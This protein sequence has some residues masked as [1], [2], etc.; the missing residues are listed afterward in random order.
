MNSLDLELKIKEIDPSNFQ[1]ICDAILQAEKNIVVSLG[2][3][4][5]CGKVRKGTPDSYTIDKSDNSFSFIECTTQLTDLENKISSDIDKCIDESK[6]LKKYKLKKILYF[7]NNNNLSPSS[8]EALENKCDLLGIGFQI[9]F[10]NDICS[11]LKKHKF[12]IRDFFNDT[13][14]GDDVFSLDEFVQF[15][16]RYKGVDHTFIYCE[17]TEDEKEILSSLENNFITT[18]YGDPGVGKSMLVV[19]TL[20]KTGKE[21]FCVNMSNEDS[22]EE[23][24]N[25]L[26]DNENFIIFIDDVNEV[27]S[28]ERFLSSFDIEKF[29]CFKVVCT[30]REYA[31][32]KLSGI[33]SKFD[34]GMSCV[35]IQRLEDKSIKTIVSENLKITNP[36]WLEKICMIAKGNPR[37]AFMAGKIAKDKGSKYLIDSKTI[38]KEYFSTYNSES[39]SKIISEY[40]DVLGIIAFLNRTDIKNE[41]SFNDLLNLCNIDKQRLITAIPILRDAELIDVFEK[42]VIQIND[43]NLSDYLIENA[44]IEHKICSIFDLIT[45]FITTKKGQIINS[46]NI[47]LNIYSCEENREYIKEEVRKSWDFLE[48]INN[49]D[50]FVKVFYHFDANRAL[51]YCNKK[52]TSHYQLISENPPFKKQ[53]DHNDFINVIK[54]LASDGVSEAFDCLVALLSFDNIRNYS[55]E[56]L[57]ELTILT[58]DNF[59]NDGVINSLIFNIEKY[60][61]NNWFNDVTVELINE[62]LNFEF[63]Y[64]SYEKDMKILFSRFSIMDDYPGIIEY[65]N[66][67][68]DICNLLDDSHKYLLIKR[69][70]N[71]CP[72]NESIKIYIND[73]SRISL[74]IKSIKNV[75]FFTEKILKIKAIDKL[76][77]FKLDEDIF[78]IHDETDFNLLKMILDPKEERLLYEERKSKRKNEIQLFAEHS[79]IN[80]IKKSIVLCNEVIL[81]NKELGWKVHEY[82]TS[83]LEVLDDEKKNLLQDINFLKDLFCEIKVQIIKANFLSANRFKTFNLL[84]ANLSLH[85]FFECC[86]VVFNCLEKSEIDETTFM[87]F[88]ECLKND[89][90][91]TSEIIVNRRT[92]TLF[93]FSESDNDFVKNI[94]SIYNSREA[95]QNKVHCWLDLLFNNYVFKPNDLVSKFIEANELELLENLVFFEAAK[96][97]SY[98]L[99]E[100]VYLI[101]NFDKEF[102]KRVVR[103]LLDFH[104]SIH[105]N[106]DLLRNL[107]SFDNS[108]LYA[109]TIFEEFVKTD[110]ISLKMFFLEHIFLPSHDFDKFIEWAKNKVLKISTEEEYKS[111]MELVSRC[112]IE[113]SIDIYIACIDNKISIDLFEQILTYPSSSSWSGSEVN[114]V[115]PKIE[116]IRKILSSVPDGIEYLE[117]KSSLKR[118]EEVLLKYCKQI[119]IREKIEFGDRF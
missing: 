99:Y 31:L 42:Q 63:D 43:Q 39:V 106:Y 52:L 59:N 14:N 70:L 100:Y 61:E 78:Y 21:V 92:D 86:F 53:N 49:L 18:V 84:K 108:F 44:F 37:L 17:R 24:N 30:I 66:R 89:L 75:D 74:L 71:K 62:S 56:A 13:L 10:L 29:N 51:I 82:L 101:S 41:G 6:K 117:Y 57:K 7:I 47:L 8:F 118:Y 67:L 60:K 112:S 46:L 38:L 119:K 80:Q 16:R 36:K 48:S 115:N 35:K 96:K 11:L 22:L 73:L 23:I 20:K 77:Y 105:S 103:E 102:L 3:C 33:L 12:L 19:Q 81:K 40:Y 94:K 32:P 45:K 34:F 83:L 104:S 87:L 15:T 64:S 97:N 111:L 114:V 88:K 68:W 25:F 113:K 58:P 4:E 110:F 2:N 69:F 109:D 72:Q 26:K 65:R 76:S 28:F 98:E 50:E 54:D 93:K 27:S 79:S 91:D 107:W 5:G 95:N 85:D 116:R 1:R 55:F 90:L 9:Y